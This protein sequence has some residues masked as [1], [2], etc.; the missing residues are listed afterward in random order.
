MNT[1]ERLTCLK[2]RHSELDEDIQVAYENFADDWTVN[3]LKKQ[4]L[5]I[6][7]RITELEKELDIV[8][9]IS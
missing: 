4:K 5:R 2:N 7:D 9:R 6:R 3:N 8:P 1:H